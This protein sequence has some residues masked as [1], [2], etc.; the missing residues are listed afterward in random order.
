LNFLSLFKRGLIYKL[1][2]KINIDLDE[3]DHL[4][5]DELFSHYGTDKSEYSNEKQNKTHGFS[6]YYVKHLDFFKKKNIK[7]LEIGSF[8][9]AS[10]AAFSKYFPKSEIFCL[11]INISNFKYH[12]NKI[13]VFGL[14][15]S[16]QKMVLNFFQKINLQKSFK[17]FDII[18]DD[19]SHKL[20]DQLKTLNIFY[21]YLANG[22]FYVIE[23]YKFSN[24]FK[25]LNDINE[26]NVDELA[27]N[28]ENKNFFSSSLLSNETID[29]L[30]N[31]IKN[32]YRYK[33]NTDISD[34]VF[35]EKN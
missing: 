32:V 16:S 3:L 17:Y 33:G 30:M 27:N 7:I 28:I 9:G 35:F 19:G 25:H 18:I 4:S 11:D 8:S 5:L 26:I 34:I 6:K 21:K 12:S 13:H 15:S 29:Q 22:G 20:S 24:Y 23:D 10:A 2:K 1:K 31:T 14:N